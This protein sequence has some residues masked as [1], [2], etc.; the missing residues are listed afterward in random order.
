MKKPLRKKTFA[1]ITAAFTKP[2]AELQTF[3]DD[4]LRLSEVALAD[5]EY[6]KQ[7]AQVQ[8]DIANEHFNAA[9]DAGVFKSKLE[10]F[11]NS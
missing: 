9:T 6:H 7:Q 10:A 4:K 3:I 2:I 11:L 8:Q 1:D 5:V